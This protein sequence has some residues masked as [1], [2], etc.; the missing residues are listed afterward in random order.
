MV[1]SHCNHQNKCDMVEYMVGIHGWKIVKGEYMTTV[2]DVGN[3]RKHVV[4]VVNIK[5]WI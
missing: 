5:F 3:G 2:M 1:Y 4:I